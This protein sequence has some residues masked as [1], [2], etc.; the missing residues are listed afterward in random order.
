VVASAVGGI[1]E[2]VEDGVTG[3]LV[4]YD[5]KEPAA[6]ESALAAAVNRVVADPVAAAG[7]GEAGRE[8]AVSAFGWDAVARRTVK[9]YESVLTT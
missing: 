8:R 2:V 6:F 3:E 4:A 1:P 5:E 7:M 9:V